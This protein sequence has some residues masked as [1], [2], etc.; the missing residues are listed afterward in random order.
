MS[1]TNLVRWSRDGDQFHYL[2]AARRCLR[3]LSAQD[4]LVAI[5]IEGPSPGEGVSDPPADAGEEVIDI[6]EYYRSEDIDRARLVRY[7]QLKHSTLHATE[8]WTASG[9]EKTIVGFVQLY[10]G[11]LQAFP[12]E[13]VA[14]KVEFW[15]VTNRPIGTDFTDAVADAA[16]QASPRHPNELE[17]LERFTGLQGEA[18]AAFSKLLHFEGRQDDYWDQRNI[19]FQDVSDYLPDADFDAPLQLKELVT[20]RALSEGEKSSTIT[21]MD[22]LRALNTDESR[23][24]PAP[25]LIQSPD[26]AVPRTQEP[27]LISAIIGATAPV[28]VHATAGVGKTVF[29]TRI[30]RG[31][32]DG[33]TCILYDCFGNGQ[34][35]NASG[36]RHRHK[37]ALVQ[38]ANELA[39]KGLCHP[40]ISTSHADATSYVRAF[41]HRIR[42]SAEK[43]RLAHA[44]AL[45]CIVVDAADNAQMA[46]EEIG[47]A[48]SFVRDLIREKIPVNVRLVFLCRTHR[49]DK[50]DPPIEAIQRVLRPFSRDETAAYLRQRFPGASERDIDEFHRLS[51]QNPRVQAL[52]LSRND[53]LHD[54]LRL[55]GPNP[56]TV[57]DTIGGLL[58][59]AIAKLRDSIGPV[60]KTQVDRIC[61]G[62]AALRPLIPIPI[63]S[64]M[65]G[66]TEAAIRSFAI[67]LGRPLLVTGDSIQFFDEPAETWFR[68]KFQPP[69]GAMDEFIASLKPLAAASAYVASALPQ[70][71]LAA[72]RFPDLV[73]LAL[74][75][76]AL[77]ETSP[78]EKRDVELQRLQ[79][80]VKAALRSK[81]YL[82]AARLALKAGGE[83]AGDDR[84]RKI[85]QC[86]TDLAATFLE[87]DR[88]E[89]IVSRRTFGSGW[90]GSHHAYEAAFLSGRLELVGDARSRLRM[91]Y[92]WLR[93]WNRLTPEE[94]KEEGISD[95]DIVELTLARINI[96]GPADGAH[97]LRSWRPREVS[98][99]VGRIVTR[100]LID[101][102]RFY[103]AG[104]FA[105]AAG[106][107]LCL[108][109]AVAVELREIQ[110]TL[111]PEL[112]R[113]AFRLVAHRGVKLRDGHAWDDQE[114]ALNAVTALV[115]ASLQHAVCTPEAAVVVLSRYLPSEPPRALSSRFT[116]SPFPVLR[117]YCLRAAL[118]GQV[119]ELRDLAHAELRAEMDKT[120]Q[121]SKS[122]DLQ[123]FEEVIGTLLPWHQLSVATLLGQ[124]T[125]AS[126][127]DELRRTREASMAA[128]KVYYRDDFPTSNEIARL[129]LD[130]L[131]RI[132]TADA[133]TLAHFL[134]WKDALKRPLFTPTLTALARSLGQKEA[135]KR[136]ALR[137]ALEA[138]KIAKD[139][140][141]DAENKSE[142]YI[143]AARA[144]LSVSK[145]DAK[146]FFNEAVEVA[147]KIGGENLS[148]W[149]AI[150][151]L[152]DRAAR[153]DRPSPETAYNFARCAELTYDYVDR[154]KYFNWQATV[155]ALC[156]LCPSSSLAILS[157]WRD[158]GFGRSE[159]ILAIGIERLVERGSLDAQDAL[160]LIGFRA[161]WSHDR[162]L[163]SVLAVCSTPSE[164]G[165]A[166]A[167]LYRYMQFG[168]GDFS[169]L[170]EVASRHGMTIP[171]IDEVVAFEKKRK[172]TEKK[173]ETYRAGRLVE[174]QSEPAVNWDEVFAGSDLTNADGVVRTYAAFKKTEPPFEHDQFFEEAIRRVPVGSE[175]AFI[176]AVGNIP[177]FDLYV[178][179]Y[180]LNQVPDTWKGRPA[181]THALA[182]TVKALCRRYCMVVAKSRRYEVLPLKMACDV[183]GMNE[184]DIAEVVLDA[185]GATPDPADS[186]RLFSLV[187]LL[188]IKLSEDQALEALKFGLELFT[189]ILEDRDGDGPWSSKLLPPTD[190]KASL[191]G[192]IW[193]SMA[194]RE[195]VSRWEGSHVVLGLV[196]LER[197]D[198]LNHVMNLAREKKGG[199]FVDAKLPFY[200]LHAL[201]WFL[202]GIARAAT[203]F[204]ATLTPFVNQIVDWALKDQPH[205]LIRQFAARA[206]LALVEHGV[207]ADRE[208]LKDRLT[209][210]NESPLAVVE[211]KSYRHTRPKKTHASTASDD[212]RYYFGLDIGPYWYEP[213]GR[214]FAL[215]QDEVETE[216]LKV[217][218][219]EFGFT[220]KGRWDEDERSKRKLYEENHTYYQGTHPRADTLHFYHAYHAMMVV[221][222]K[223]LARMP[224]YRDPEFGEEDEFAVWLD[225][226]D[227]SRKDRRWLWDR[228]DPTPLEHPSWQDRKRE[229]DTLPVVTVDDFEEGLHAGG[230]LLNVWGHWT[231]ADSELEQSVHISSALLS[232]DKSLALLRALATAK[233]VH[234]YALPSA[235]SD[236]EIDESGFTLKGWIVDDSRDRGLD[237]QDRWA[238]GISFPP[239]ILAPYVIEMMGLETDS[240]RR[241]WR[242]REKSVVMASQV[243]G[244]YDEAR[245]HES[246]NPEHGSRIQAS[247]GFLTTLL[248]K[249]GRD[250]IIEVQIDRRRRSQPYGSRVEYDKERIPTKARL[251]L[252][253]ADGR[254]RTL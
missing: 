108:V 241:L 176:E 97:S 231:A 6:A 251:Y 22:V 25:C 104:E 208:N 141:S 242:D 29:A 223:L 170:K 48:R 200:T 171:G 191:A 63:V 222:G 119:L 120:N 155:E 83:T 216:A 252:L 250:L 45:L 184:A 109:L 69:A 210:V 101:H 116:K 199:P 157:R 53:T 190:I 128:A 166:L 159:E 33:S 17:K 150:L 215:G 234:D 99:R 35:R 154:D 212:D 105:R 70:L 124:I 249:L 196:A 66:V 62:L 1:K 248:A 94:R 237:G 93:N 79:F 183:A 20:R 11:R 65:S 226:H 193:A 7:M 225:R 19:L 115:E 151:D 113:R 179:R 202:I 164:K 98:F 37:D 9:L 42:Q 82:D 211:S 78:L 76:S 148:R 59:G 204:P 239:P 27:E 182:D 80:A 73:E 41:L 107:N 71:M 240:D 147:S 174:T 214:V 144:I 123:E 181:T 23:L 205:V 146:E 50:L 186:N 165:A 173:S 198:V 90:H 24:F 235:G 52:A 26:A 74:T 106:N 68:E 122:S 188:A 172:E 217:I 218:R 143:D 56:T 175:A 203:E 246:S 87:T 195:G 112:A 180:F 46:A 38:I 47:E 230:G 103:D 14:S 134:E 125:K 139:E 36:Y 229:K 77:P 162:L 118:R 85:L 244:H 12:I 133:T 121:Y 192:Y 220:G 209:R 131:Q 31:L 140:R 236:R 129:W 253:G 168:N 100:R 114:S 10:L 213:L 156:D 86:N 130:I 92:E 201:Q 55:L 91:A 233:D 15:F 3:L 149:D 40:L 61:A 163:D 13:V 96:H 189:P 72:G 111:D 127:G 57:E 43:V 152:A 39:A 44:Q 126:L 4:D 177:D 142:G 169:K 227:L 54:T 243:W 221:A 117:A 102:G 75:S 232:P 21:K 95:Q 2:W 84:Q 197:H 238:G 207:L 194:A 30:A 245:R 32:P 49:L 178:F 51:S 153:I 247:L 18:L 185:V 187:G 145:S 8:P 64:K 219:T 138:F 88:I 110:R 58:E 67:D 161:D 224:T 135:T 137:F 28:I 89:E 254:L 60:E 206:A 16:A 136:A 5:S 34:Y 167:H 228:R 158:R 81:R 132:D 160:P